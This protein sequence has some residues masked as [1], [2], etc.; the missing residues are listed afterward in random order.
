MVVHLPISSRRAID[1]RPEN[2]SARVSVLPICEHTSKPVPRS[3]PIK[4]RATSNFAATPIH[5]WHR[6]TIITD[7]SRCVFGEH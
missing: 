7:K 2:S 6:A 3:K 1:T 5:H 4:L